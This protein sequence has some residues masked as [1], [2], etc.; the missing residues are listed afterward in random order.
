MTLALSSEQ[1]NSQSVPGFAEELSHFLFSL[2]ASPIW[3][4]QG[5]PEDTCFLACYFQSL[6]PWL[7]L[8]GCE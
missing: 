2:I 7:V 5:S 6:D 3:E 1:H 4:A 8:N